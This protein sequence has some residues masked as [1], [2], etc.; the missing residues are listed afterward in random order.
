VT[1]PVQVVA[2]YTIPLVLRRACG[3]VQTHDAPAQVWFFL[4]RALPEDKLSEFAASSEVEL[5]LETLDG[6]ADA[7]GLLD[8]SDGRSSVAS[9]V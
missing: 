1:Q 8:G 2:L 9:A 3:P 7:D 6:D 5:N 4:S